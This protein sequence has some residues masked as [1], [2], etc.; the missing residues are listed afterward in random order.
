MRLSFLAIFSWRK[1]H[2]C[3]IITMMLNISS[4]VSSSTLCKFVM[5]GSQ[6]R[7]TICHK[8]LWTL[9]SIPFSEREFGHWAS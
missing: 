6:I 4:C 3:P 2:S 9:F 7:R 1:L 5:P 8:T